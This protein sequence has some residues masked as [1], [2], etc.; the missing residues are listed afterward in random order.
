MEE[1]PH[2][3]AHF[4]AAG[5]EKRLEDYHFLR[6]TYETITGQEIQLNRILRMLG[7]DEFTLNWRTDLL[8]MGRGR[9][10]S[11]YA[12][13]RWSSGYNLQGC[14]AY[15]RLR[16][17]EHDHS[18]HTNLSTIPSSP[19]RRV[20]ELRER[21]K[22][23]SEPPD[24]SNRA[25]SSGSITSSAR[26]QSLAE[27]DTAL[28]ESE[29]K[30]QR[31]AEENRLNTLKNDEND[32]MEKRREKFKTMF[33]NE[34]QK[35]DKS[36]QEKVESRQE[37]AKSRQE[38]V[39]SRQEKVKSR[40]EEV[41]SRQEK[42]KSREDVEP[43]QEVESRQGKG[44]SKQEEVESRQEEVESRQEKVKSRQEVESRHEEI[45]SEQEEVESRQEKGDS[46]Q[47]EVESRQEEVESRQKVKSRQEKG[48]SKQ[49]EVELRQEEVESRQEKVKSRQEKV[50]SRQ[51]VESRQEEIESEQEVESR[52]EKG[53]S[54]QDKVES[55]KHLKENIP[56]IEDQKKNLIK[57][58]KNDS[59]DKIRKSSIAYDQEKSGD[60]ELTSFTV[61]WEPIPSTDKNQDENNSLIRLFCQWASPKSSSTIDYFTIERQL[62]DQEW[63]SIGEK[64]NKLKNQTQF[65]ISLLNE[66]NVNIPS[67]FRLKA[68]LKSGQTFTS[69]PTDEIFMHLFEDKNIIIPHVEILSS[70]SVQLTWNDNNNDEK[71]NIYDIEKKEQEE[72]EQQQESEWEKVIEVPLSQRSARIDSLTDAKQ[73]QFRLIPSTSELEEME[74]TDNEV[75]P[76][77]LTVHNV[78]EL[79]NSLHINP[80]STN[81]V[82]IDISDEGFNE[83]DCYKIEYTTTDQRNQWK[84]VSDITQD[85]PHLTIDNLKQG[86]N[87]KFRF[88]PIVSG[89]TTTNGTDTSQL[90]L[91]LD[92]KMPSARKGRFDKTET[93]TETETPVTVQPQ[94]S[95]QKLDSTSVLVE[96]IVPTEEPATFEDVYDIYS[97]NETTDDDDWNKV[98]TIDKEHLSTT[99]DNLEE[100]TPYSF[101]IDNITSSTTDDQSNTVQEF[102][103]E[104][105]P[106]K[107]YDPSLLLEKIDQ[108]LENVVNGVMKAAAGHQT[109]EEPVNK[110]LTEVIK[111]VF[112]DEA[113]VPSEQYGFDTLALHDD[114]LLYRGP[115]QMMLKELE[116]DE[117]SDLSKHY[118]EIII[119]NYRT[120]KQS[121]IVREENGNTRVENIDGDIII[122]NVVSDVLLKNEQTHHQ[123]SMNIVGQAFLKGV[124]GTLVASKFK[125][126][127]VV[128]NVNKP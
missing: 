54:K 116:V 98:G 55:N 69:K 13:D 83:F 5:A 89:T 87:Y 58:Q 119:H 123:L 86:T 4:M 27:Y 104:T 115:K 103:F 75:E 37:K 22:R 68:H 56:L 12:F 82:D 94:F 62:G 11:A 109:L 61:R 50:K 95:I 25:G 15:E 59:T 125:G 66:I 64:I 105:T 90:S 117:T 23:L 124:Q 97:K 71:T 26:L 7:E 21:R 84:Q 30:R 29:T 70:N 42:V 74:K 3:I 20:Q 81:T 51:E 128:K 57:D 111:E 65:D 31:Q 127:I 32:L 10:R 112:R 85:D 122:R 14:I 39:E 110:S 67:Y 114:L 6:N 108:S 48:D 49:E 35:Y 28:A 76:E 38:E 43:R 45:E 96:A 52:Q 1:T 78:N 46:K 80:T 16:D 72:E 24:Y 18:K 77:V 60:I 93:K 17:L 36:K 79:L 120:R 126:I 73:T 19:S 63:L 118:G 113:L 101:K 88:T 100:N 102:K 91:V 47:E 9:Y 53:E 41:E 44:D 34:N 99:I 107:Q 2:L 121:V 40:Q 8:P 106:V 92:V 33:D